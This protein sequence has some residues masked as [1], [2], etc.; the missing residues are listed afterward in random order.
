MHGIA[1]LARGLATRSDARGFAYAEQLLELCGDPTFGSAAGRAIGVV[2][3]DK[4]G[5]LVKEN[6]A[7]I[8]VCWAMYKAFA[9]KFRLS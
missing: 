5:L 1:W 2:T 6:H 7:I 9:A 3:E 8:R 4:D